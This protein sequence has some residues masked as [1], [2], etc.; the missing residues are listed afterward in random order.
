MFFSYILLFS[1]LSY[2]IEK[3][4]NSKLFVQAQLCKKS[5]DQ[6]SKKTRQLTTVIDCFN[7]HITISLFKI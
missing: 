7:E 6:K 2:R 1:D 4:L 3:K 5:M